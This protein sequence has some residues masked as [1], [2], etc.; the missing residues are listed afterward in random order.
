LARSG[1][2]KGF[3]AVVKYAN[4]IQID[5]KVCLALSA[6]LKKIGV[7]LDVQEVTT[8]Q[9]LAD[10]YAHKPRMHVSLFG[11]DYPDPA[12][13][14]AIKLGSAGA[15]PNGQNFAN[16]KNPTIDRLLVEQQSATSARVRARVIRRILQIAATDLPYLPVVWQDGAM[17]ISSKYTFT[18]FSPWYY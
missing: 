15:I 1:Y 7:T 17:A 3:K 9:W 11:A 4:G 14:I 5:G 8:D 13:F 10:L 6:S 16:Y 2:P 18:G 12:N